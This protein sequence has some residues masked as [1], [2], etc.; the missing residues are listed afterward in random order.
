[1]MFS[2]GVVEYIVVLSINNYNM[3][4]APPRPPVMAPSWPRHGPVMVTDPVMVP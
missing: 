2:D 1:M 4:S 3:S